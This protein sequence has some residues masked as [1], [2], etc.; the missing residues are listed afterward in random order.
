[1]R[2]GICVG[3]VTDNGYFVRLMDKNGYYPHDDSTNY[4][5]RDIWEIAFKRPEYP[6]SLPH[7]EDICVMGRKFKGVL[8]SSISMIDFLDS[9]NVF[10]YRGCLSALFESK[11]RFT[12][13]GAGFIDKH[14]IPQNSVCFWVPD[15]ELFSISDYNGRIRYNYR[16]DDRRRLSISYVGLSHPVNIIPRGMLL[17]MSLAHWW[18]P[19]GSNDDERCYLL[20]SGW[21]NDE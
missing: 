9:K 18:K 21:F 4:E 7:S 15:K 5:I 16:H 19:V 13:N 2:Q 14:D 12:H 3:G 1:M 20:L 11:L 6:R 10:I 8:H 17:R